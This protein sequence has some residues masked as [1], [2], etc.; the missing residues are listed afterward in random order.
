[1]YREKDD[2]LTDILDTLAKH[3]SY[4]TVL[5]TMLKLLRGTHL[6]VAALKKDGGIVPLSGEV[7]YGCQ[8]EY[9]WGPYK[10]C[11]DCRGSK[12]H[13]DCLACHILFKTE[14][15]E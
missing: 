4:P 15:G 10:F 9:K 14:A 12:E 7:D 2:T 8:P 5:A 13:W 11:R 6:K 3:Y 1:M